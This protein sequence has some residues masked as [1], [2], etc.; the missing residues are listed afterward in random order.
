MVPDN[1]G[2]LEQIK[3]SGEEESNDGDQ[4]SITYR[5]QDLPV[6]V[7]DVQYCR[8]IGKLADGGES[9]SSLGADLGLIGLSD[10]D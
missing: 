3:L 9:F 7:E 6:G 8:V 2:S 5:S 10:T 1:P 4:D